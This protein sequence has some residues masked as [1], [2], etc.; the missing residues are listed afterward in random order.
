MQITESNVKAS[1]T[2]FAEPSQSDSDVNE[3]SE[4][5]WSRALI[6]FESGNRRTGVW[7]KA[8]SDARGDESEAKALYIRARAGQLAADDNSQKRTT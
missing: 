7:A 8:F 4:E 1:P 6:E 5:N 3:P 2:Q